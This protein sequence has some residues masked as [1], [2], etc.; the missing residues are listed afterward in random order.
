MNKWQ[1]EFPP[2]VQAERETVLAAQ[3][4]AMHEGTAEAVREAQEM[5]LA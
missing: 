3:V 1:F 4:R 2:E 5:A